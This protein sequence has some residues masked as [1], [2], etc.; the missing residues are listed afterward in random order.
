MLSRYPH[1]AAALVA[2]IY[3]FIIGRLAWCAIARWKSR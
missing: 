1:L 3:G 2:I